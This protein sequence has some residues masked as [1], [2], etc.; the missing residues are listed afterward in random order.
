MGYVHDTHMSQYIPPTAMMPITGTWTEVAGQVAGTI[1]KHK[2]AA[3]E[4]SV[5]YIP[6]PIPSNSAVDV[7]G[8]PQKGSNIKSIEFD[9]EVLVAAC[10]SVT[11]ALTKI[12]RGADGAVAVVSTITATQD[13]AAASVAA[14]VDQH[15]L[16]LTVTTPFYIENDEELVATLTFVAAAT[17]TLDV[18]GAVANYDARL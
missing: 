3:A 9:Y 5:V 18:L 12:K 11:A 2:A 7:S 10:T 4:T 14:G 13:L 16:T 15:K 8:A 1:C 6:I 17:T